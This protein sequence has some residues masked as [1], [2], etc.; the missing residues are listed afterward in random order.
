MNCNAKTA[1]KL[2][3]IPKDIIIQFGMF[4]KKKE[5]ETIE[6]M[7]TYEEKCI[8]IIYRCAFVQNR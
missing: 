8:K 4:G 5:E 7:F 6:N 1:Q 3:K 2:W